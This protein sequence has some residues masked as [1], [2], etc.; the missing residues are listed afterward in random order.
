MKRSSRLITTTILTGAVF[1][2]SACQP[3]PYTHMSFTSTDACYRS[4]DSINDENMTY[5]NWTDLCDTQFA[6]AEKEHLKVAPKYEASGTDGDD[7]CEEV[8][9]DDSCYKVTGNDGSSYFVPFMAGYLISSMMV[10]NRHSY[11]SSSQPIYKSSTGSFATANSSWAT[12]RLNTKQT[13]SRPVTT[14]PAASKINTPQSVKSSGG[15]GASRTS[16]SAR[17]VAGG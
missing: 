8:H 16:M 7:L 14:A 3:E 9:G 1:A 6:N 5:S 2:T 12:S 10:N 15:F 17:G 11:M 13:A 4:Y